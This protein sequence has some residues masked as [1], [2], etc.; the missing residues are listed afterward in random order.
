[1]ALYGLS[2][3]FQ[4]AFYMV[5][6]EGLMLTGVILGGLMSAGSLG[7][8]SSHVVGVIAVSM[9]YGTSVPAIEACSCTTINIPRV[10][11]VIN[12]SQIIF[13]C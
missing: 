11:N 2:V 6:N 7:L 3:V 1:M 9:S 10:A 4:T 8:V 5:H 13:K 12:I